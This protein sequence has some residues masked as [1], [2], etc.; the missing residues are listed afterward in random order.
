MC[1]SCSRCIQACPTDAI[2]QPYVLDATKC[3]S[4]LTIEY[5]DR[6]I[7]VAFSGKFNQYV[8][9]CDICQEVCPWNK[10][11]KETSENAY[12]PKNENNDMRF[13][14]LETMSED[15]FKLRFNKS[16][17]RRTGW[18]NFIRNVKFAQKKK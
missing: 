3:I 1:G 18:K 16:P 17:V 9:G 2:I 14:D 10:Y 4:Y 6:P 13:E 11:Q 7:P 5:W 15:E 12:L 8:F